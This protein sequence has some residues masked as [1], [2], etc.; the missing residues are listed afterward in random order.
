MFHY[1]YQSTLKH[2]C[3]KGATS[4]LSIKK[5]C[6]SSVKETLYPLPSNFHNP[7]A[8]LNDHSLT[9]NQ[10]LRM[11]MP[12][13]IHN[14]LIQHLVTIYLRNIFFLFIWLHFCG[15]WGIHVSFPLDLPLKTPYTYSRCCILGLV[16][17][18]RRCCIG[19]RNWHRSD[20]VGWPWMT[21][22]LCEDKKVAF[23]N[24]STAAQWWSC[25]NT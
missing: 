15:A 7:P 1:I 11:S 9:R 20:K 2:G 12:I 22:V 24:D 8:I 10:P 16:N 6:T 17:W 21:S 13:W 25:K 4:F 18:H 5:T 14:K 19:L 23:S 3:K